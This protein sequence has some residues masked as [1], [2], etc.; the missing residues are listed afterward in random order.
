MLVGVVFVESSG[1]GHILETTFAVKPHG[2]KL[3]EY[4]E[5]VG[6]LP[7]DRSGKQISFSS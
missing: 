2:N 4:A 6:L 7:F 5:S 3:A 1:T